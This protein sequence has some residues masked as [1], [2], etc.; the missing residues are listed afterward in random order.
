MSRWEPNARERLQE[1]AL[2]LFAGRGY[3]RTTI[4]DIAARAGLTDRTFFRYFSDKPDVLFVRSKELENG[5]VY[6]IVSS[7]S[8]ATPLEVVS[9]AFEAAG[10]EVLGGRDP[11]LVRAR[12]TLVMKHSELLER[13]LIKLASLT[14]A[15]TRALHSRGVAEPAASLAAEAG[16]AVFKVGFQ[17]WVS[18]KKPQEFAAELRAAM[19]AFR[20]MVAEGQAPTLRARARR[21]GKT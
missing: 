4:G 14:A 6:L 5:I 10:T 21:Q 8:E 17:R 7:P 18:Q 2:E 11:H 3:D 9:A 20:A 15:I 16:M 12:H 1:A 13:E 19:V